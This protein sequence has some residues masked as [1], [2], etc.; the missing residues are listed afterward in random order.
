MSP[1]NGIQSARAPGTHT[2]PPTSSN[3]L[4]ATT[5]NGNVNGA[6]PRRRTFTLGPSASSSSSGSSASS[7]EEDDDDDDDDDDEEASVV[8]APP[9]PMLRKRHRG[10][11][12]RSSLLLR[13]PRHDA[14]EEEEEEEDEEEE[15]EEDEGVEVVMVPVG[16]PAET[17]FWG[18]V[19]LLSTWVVFV[20]GMGSVLGVWEWAWAWGSD[21]SVSASKKRWPRSIAGEKQFPGEFPIPG[22]YPAICILTCIMAWVWVVVAWVGMKYFKHAK[23]QS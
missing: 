23:I 16:D 1:P 7:S 4:P 5:T 2:A 19:V 15:E 21:V 8:A 20:V 9:P 18:W 6:R 17:M 3:G 14:E 13:R 12:L 10:Y 22:Y 11:S